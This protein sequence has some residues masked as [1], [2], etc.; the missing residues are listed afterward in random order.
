[1]EG[2]EV[3]MIGEE[4]EETLVTYAGN[5]GILQQCVLNRGKPYPQPLKPKKTR[6]ALRGRTA[7]PINKIEE[8]T[9]EN[10]ASLQ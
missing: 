10:N 1:M 8:E 2:Q 6:L 9:Q 4:L 5:R 7:V 3:K